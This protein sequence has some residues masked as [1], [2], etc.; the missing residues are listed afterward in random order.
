[1]N[2]N[3]TVNGLLF[4]LLITFSYNNIYAQVNASNEV[5]SK[6]DEINLL[7]KGWHKLKTNRY[8]G[9]Q[10]DIAFINETKGW[11]VNGYGSIYH[12]QNGGETWEK[13][14]EKK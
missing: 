8:P 4:L 9:K 11:Y 7:G 3:K 12:T 13:Q 14:L 1:M 6:K 10:D 2:N 5:L